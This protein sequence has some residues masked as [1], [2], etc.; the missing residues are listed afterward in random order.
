ML[1]IARHSGTMCGWS[2]STS[3]PEAP[4]TA[5]KPEVRKMQIFGL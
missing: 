3:I 5:E 4:G 1:S 2:I